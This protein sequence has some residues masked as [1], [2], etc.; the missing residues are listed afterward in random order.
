MPLHDSK[1]VGDKL[2]CHVFVLCAFNESM[3]GGIMKSAQ[4]LAVLILLVAVCSRQT[5]GKE[6]AENLATEQAVGQLE[7]VA[8]FNG[9]MPTGVTVANNGRIFVNFPKWGDNVEYTVAEVKDGET[10]PYPNA[11]INRYVE[12]D[13]PSDKLLSVQS[14][15]VDPT[16]NRL[17]ILDTASFSF[18]PVKSNGG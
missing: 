16:G 6:F 7:V 14:V 9:P 5:L 10:V 12:G 8:I 4:T 13:N 18:G 15:V 2:L 17:W 11:D 3:R 1:Q